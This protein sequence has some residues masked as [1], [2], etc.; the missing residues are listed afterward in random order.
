MARDL[1][2][3]IDIVESAFQ[4]RMSKVYTN[5]IALYVNAIYKLINI[6]CLM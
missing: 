5:N 1:G 2:L 3:V 6:N 4:F